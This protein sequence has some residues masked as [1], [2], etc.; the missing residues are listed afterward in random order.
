[1]SV[2]SNACQISSDFMSQVNND[3]MHVIN[4]RRRLELKSKHLLLCCEGAR[5]FLVGASASDAKEAG[6][7]ISAGRASA[8]ITA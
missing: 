2:A 1:M 4:R 7:R 5:S 3:N 6:A 8:S